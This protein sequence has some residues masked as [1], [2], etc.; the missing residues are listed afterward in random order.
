[1]T[2]A[3]ILTDRLSRMGGRSRLSALLLFVDIVN[4]VLTF[5]GVDGPV[6]FITG[7]ILG[8]V[9]PGWAI[10]GVLRIEDVPLLVGLTL[11][12][13]LAVL[14][15]IAQIFLSIHFWHPVA[16]EEVI[17]VLSAGLLL[18]QIRVGR[19]YGADDA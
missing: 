17:S 11:A 9:I 5:T 10:V 19:T 7:L 14:L 12:V 18:W 2:G 15:I 4:L 1:M 6:R 13:S 8:L 3:H 16:M